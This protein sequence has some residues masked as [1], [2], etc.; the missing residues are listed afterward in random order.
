M[1]RHCGFVASF[2]TTCENPYEIQTA[3]DTLTDTAETN[4]SGPEGETRCAVTTVGAA[5]R[6]VTEVNVV[7]TVVLVE[8]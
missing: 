3:W 7:A 4:D 5:M 2:R 6:I 1:M 8:D